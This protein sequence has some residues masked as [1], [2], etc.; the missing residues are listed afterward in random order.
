LKWITKEHPKIDRVACPWL[1]K[2][3]IDKNGEIIF[4]PAEDIIPK[5]MKLDAI[6]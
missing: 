4:V 1:I 5:A 6:P 3:F 2:R